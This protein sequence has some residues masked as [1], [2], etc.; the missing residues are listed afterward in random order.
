MYKGNSSLAEDSMPFDEYFVSMKDG[1][2]VNDFMAR[3]K[4]ITEFSSVDTV[5]IGGQNRSLLVWCHPEIFVGPPLRL[6]VDS[7]FRVPL[8]GKIPYSVVESAEYNMKLANSDEIS[9]QVEFLEKHPLH[10]DL[11]S[12]IISSAP[13]IKK[14]SSMQPNER[15]DCIVS[16]LLK[17]KDRLSRKKSASNLSLASYLKLHTI[18]LSV[19]EEA[20][21]SKFHPFHDGDMANHMRMEGPGIP[22]FH[23]LVDLLQSQPIRSIQLTPQYEF[24]HLR[25]DCTILKYFVGQLNDRSREVIGN[26]EFRDGFN[27]VFLDKHNLHILSLNDD[28]S[29]ITVNDLNTWFLLHF[30][31]VKIL[32]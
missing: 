12:L 23:I 1:Y 18:H 24:T 30:H 7:F 31:K 28:E 17:R 19:K 26:G 25:N 2:F 10:I 20:K 8:L 22:L 27:G 15:R 4:A 9:L 5:F 32:S 3:V 16:T 14:L 29:D 11:N 21:I 13:S 6:I